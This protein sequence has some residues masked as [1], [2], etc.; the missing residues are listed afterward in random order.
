[1]FE[2][3]TKNLDTIAGVTILAVSIYSLKWLGIWD[4]L[5]TTMMES[6]GTG[7]QVA[8]NVMRFLGF[9]SLPV[10]ILGAAPTV[11]W[12]FQRNQ[13]RKGFL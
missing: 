12:F 10:T 1:M 8:A 5:A 9:M 11:L 6:G 2:F 4:V 7:S 13:G 3:I